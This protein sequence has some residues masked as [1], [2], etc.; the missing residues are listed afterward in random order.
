[1][2]RTLQYVLSPADGGNSTAR[3]LREDGLQ[4]L[5]SNGPIPAH[6]VLG[7]GAFRHRAGNIRLERRLDIEAEPH[8]HVQQSNKFWIQSLYW[9]V[10]TASR[11]DDVWRPGVCNDPQ[12][13][14]GSIQVSQL[15]RW[16][17]SCL[18]ATSTGSRTR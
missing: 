13:L 8:R 1:M 6:I 18:L 9:H 2:E 15:S 4:P 14:D 3:S 10:F 16:R 11:R 12:Q 5:N 7:L 17:S